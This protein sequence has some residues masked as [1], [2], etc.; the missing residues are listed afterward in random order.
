MKRA[1]VDASVVLKWY[2]PDETH[3][4][5]ALVLLQ[6]CAAG[7]LEMLAPS[8]LTYELM[9]G[10]VIAGR[11]ASTPRLRTFA[12]LKYSRTA[13]EIIQFRSLFNTCSAR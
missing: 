3:G 7:E 13:W 1:V 2:L 10:L 4:P 12:L 5:Q 6:Q 8:L 9:N 11:R